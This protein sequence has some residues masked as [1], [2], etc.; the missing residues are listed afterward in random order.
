MNE[1]ALEGNAESNEREE[2]EEDNN[3]DDDGL[4]RAVEDEGRMNEE[5]EVRRRKK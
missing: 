3:E 4:E 2:D 5:R 1:E